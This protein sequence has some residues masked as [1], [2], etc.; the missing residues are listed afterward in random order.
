M[1]TKLE[2]ERLVRKLSR[3]KV[4]SDL[5]IHPNTLLDWELNPG[6]IKI[7]SATTLSE[8]YDCSLT[9]LFADI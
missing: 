6:S 8:Y 5:G 4:S 1:A 7:K 9:E 2:Q 3:A